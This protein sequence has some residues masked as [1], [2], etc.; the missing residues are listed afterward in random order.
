MTGESSDCWVVYSP[1]ESALSDGAGFWSNEFCWVDFDQATRF[2]MEETQRLHLP[3]SSGNDA[4]F[5]PW[6]EAQRYY[7]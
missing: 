2:S 4:R 3:I 5:I 7:R 1:S 6:Q